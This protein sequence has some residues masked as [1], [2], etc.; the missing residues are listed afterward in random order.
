[1]SGIINHLIG[2]QFAYIEYTTTRMVYTLY[3]FE[4]Y[5]IDSLY[6]RQAGEI[7]FYTGRSTTAFINDVNLSIF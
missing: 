1:M 4:M 3:V 5:Y 6:S 2:K 7:F